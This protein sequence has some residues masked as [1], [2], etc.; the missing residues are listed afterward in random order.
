MRHIKS[1]KFILFLGV[2]VALL[3][4]MAQAEEEM[5]APE[6]YIVPASEIHTIKKMLD[7]PRNLMASYPL[8]DAVPQGVYN[9]LTF[10]V[11]EAKKL[12]EEIVGIRSPD[13]VGKIA[14]DIKPGKYTYQDLEQSPEL[15]DL[16]PPEFL[17]HM[18]PAGPPLIGAIPEFE[19]I[20]TSQLYHYVKY[21]KT[22]KENLGKTKLD[23]DGYIAPMSWQGGIP[24]PRPSGSFKA[25]QVYYNYEKTAQTFES[26]VILNGESMGFD[27]NLTKDKWSL[28]Q[29]NFIRFMGRTLFPPYGWLDERARKRGEFS[30][31]G[32]L[33]YEPR[34]QRGLV[35]LAYAYDDPDKLDVTLV[36]VPSMRR[37]RKMAATDTQ[38][39]MG[40]ITYDDRGHISQKITPNKYPYKFEIISEREYLMPISYDDGGVWVDSKNGYCLRNVQFMRRPCYVLQM[41]QTDPN[42]VYSKRILYIDMEN[43]SCTISFTYDQKGRLYREQH[44]V[45]PFIPEVGQ[46]VLWGAITAQFDH[47]DEHSTFTMQV[48]LPVCFARSDFTMQYLIK[49]GK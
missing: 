7:D 39:P 40:D 46:L 25:Q 8:K 6:T 44:Y 12:H 28:Y 43:F 24:F 27:R 23:K 47:I 48:G 18:R 17:H 11:K 3:P 35:V 42:Y 37:I 31:Y 33:M 20:P 1:G 5:P 16:F 9:Y 34:A 13:M 10:D 41:N 4:L 21:N 32:N 26:C 38:D 14:P 30:S 15:K 22:T 45:W 19:I 49:M 2:I 36:Y 29:C